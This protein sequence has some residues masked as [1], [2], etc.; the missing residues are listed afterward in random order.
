MQDYARMYH[1]RYE[2]NKNGRILRNLRQLI[3]AGLPH[4]LLLVMIVATLFP[5]MV[6][7]LANLLKR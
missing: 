5:S 6:P 1:R 4:E 3:L 2:E 7:Q